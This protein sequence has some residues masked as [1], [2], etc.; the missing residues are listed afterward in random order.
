MSGIVL[1]CDCLSAQ[2]CVF[3]SRDGQPYFRKKE[4]P[5]QSGS[6]NG[7]R[8]KIL[9]FGDSVIW[10]DG[11]KPEHKIVDLV[12]QQI[13][14]ATGRPVELHAY[15]HSG[16][17]LHATDPDAKP[18]FPVF[19][20]K[21]LGD[22]D[23]ERP[24]T[25]EQAVCASKVDQ[26]AEYIL[27][28]GCINEVGAEQIALP[29]VLYPILNPGS[30]QVTPADIR[31]DALSYCSNNM[32]NT[33]I[34]I[35]HKFS[36]A[37]VVVLDYFRVVSTASKPKPLD[38]TEEARNEREAEDLQHEERTDQVVIRAQHL[39]KT[40][41]NVNAVRAAAQ[42]WSD[43]ANEFLKDST[44]C[45]KWAIDA[46]NAGAEGSLS[47]PPI[48]QQYS[49][50]DPESKWPPVCPTFD[51]ESVVIGRPPDVPIVAA[52]FPNNQEYS[53]GASDT[54]LWLLPLLFYPHDELYWTRAFE[55]SL[56]LFRGDKSCYINPI[57]HPNPKGAQCY[58]ENILGALG[59][60]SKDHDSDCRSDKDGN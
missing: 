15:A 28:D 57:A 51:K 35:T 53:Y 39:S 29:P 44:S 24:T 56:H 25:Y 17:R 50:S 36:K 27:L 47:N 46:V 55:C 11:D 2:N 3:H 38:E 1:L 34:E 7:A 23:S 4:Y 48:P 21:P 14:K 19:A 10:G 9:A 16:A 18:R 58:S 41:A 37:H 52:P 31:A 45:I 59:F 30:K 12:S 22:L 8:V 33:L 5:P 32:A 13:A 60:D 40:A 54:H 20:G 49:S 43:N 6:T 42:R 26:D